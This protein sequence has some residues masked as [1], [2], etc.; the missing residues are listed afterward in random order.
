MMHNLRMM[1]CIKKLTSLN[2][3]ITTS[4]NQIA[5]SMMKYGNGINITYG[6]VS[7]ESFAT[8]EYS[9]IKW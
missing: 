8:Y 9:F 6:E 7:D 5:S 2:T 4:I 3:T 1:K